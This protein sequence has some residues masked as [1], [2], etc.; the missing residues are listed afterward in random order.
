MNLGDKYLSEMDY[1]EAIVAFNQAIEID[2]RSVDAYL[3]L[4]DA[5]LGAGDYE[6]AA[7]ALQQGYDLTGDERLESKLKE[8][9]SEIARLKEEEE[10]RKAEEARRKEEERKKTE[11]EAWKSQFDLVAEAGDGIHCFNKITYTAEE[12]SVLD[13][14]LA[15]CKAGNLDGMAGSGIASM[16]AGEESHEKY[17]GVLYKDYALEISGSNEN[18]LYCVGNVYNINDGELGFSFG[19]N[20]G[21]T[22]DVIDIKMFQI[23]C[24]GIFFQGSYSGTGIFS[25]FVAGEYVITGRAEKNMMAEGIF[26][27]KYD[28]GCE[29]IVQEV[30]NGKITKNPTYIH[31]SNSTHVELGEDSEVGEMAYIANAHGNA[32]NI[33]YSSNI[34]QTMD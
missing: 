23:P 16:V 30:E 11:E 32:G 5:H 26:I 14:F 25:V 21:G 12:E 22:N 8:V 34:H 3:G 15:A 19:I 28:D 18:D 9:N 33:N 7:A 13:A 4:V 10:R 27:M 24:E 1:E 20:L 17:I 6:S 31:H 2:P 29:V